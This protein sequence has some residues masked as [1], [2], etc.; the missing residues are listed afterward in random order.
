MAVNFTYYYRTPNKV[1][2][3]I[4]IGRVEVIFQHYYIVDNILSVV[5]VAHMKILMLKNNRNISQN[6]LD[7]LG[8]QLLE[9]CHVHPDQLESRTGHI[10]V[11]LSGRQEHLVLY[12]TLFLHIYCALDLLEAGLKDQ[13]EF[14]QAVILGHDIFN[15]SQGVGRV[16]I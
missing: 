12:P 14:T 16:K 1:N 10:R 6:V 5:R 7:T 15:D 9:H 11:V 3:E 2:R 13:A 8:S 4:G